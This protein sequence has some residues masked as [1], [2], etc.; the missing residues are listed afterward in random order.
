MKN[1]FFYYLFHSQIYNKQTQYNNSQ[2]NH[3]PIYKKKNEKKILSSPW[4]AAYL[5]SIRSS[6]C[7]VIRKHINIFFSQFL[8]GICAELC[9]VSHKQTLKCVENLNVAQSSAEAKNIYLQK[10]SFVLNASDG[11]THSLN[12]RKRKK[13]RLKTIKLNLMTV[14]DITMMYY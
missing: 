12:K 1:F 14:N 13:K 2:H 6:D 3:N 9:D 7:N 11:E 8:S 5:L 4:N 10:F